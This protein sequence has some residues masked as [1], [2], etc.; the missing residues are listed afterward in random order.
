MGGRILTLTVTLT[1][2]GSAGSATDSEVTDIVEG[3]FLDAY[4]NYHASAPATTDIT[5]K[6]TDRSDNILVVT[7]N[8]T[9]GLYSPRQAVHTAAGAAVT[10]GH[11][12]YPVNGTLTVS[13]AQSNALTG[14]C[15][16]TIRIQTL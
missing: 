5:I 7:D 14:A 1:T 8:A 3:F 9:D 6:Q 16:V 11:D 13:A 15:V 2:T 12:K 4:L 10:N